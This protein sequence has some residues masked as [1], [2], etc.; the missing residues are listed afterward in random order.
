VTSGAPSA[1]GG[2][3]PVSTTDALGNP[4]STGGGGGDTTGDGQ[5][6]NAQAVALPV[7]LARNQDQGS[8]VP[9]A[10]A[11]VVILLLIIVAPPLFVTYL[12]SQ[13]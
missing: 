3:Q 10:V 2:A 5:S 7:D 4:V 6:V 1:S 8:D 11:A 12:R 9:Y 13:S